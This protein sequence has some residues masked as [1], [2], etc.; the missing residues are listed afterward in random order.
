MGFLDGWRARR[1]ER[2]KSMAAEARG[3]MDSVESPYA[4]ARTSLSEYEKAL[5]FSPG[6]A[7]RHAKKAYRAAVSESEAARDHTRAVEV[8]EA[9]K[10]MDERKVSSMDSDYRDA[11]AKGNTRRATKVARRMYAEASRN[12]DP[13]PVSVTLDQSGAS[14]GEVDVVVTNRGDRPVVVQSIACSCGTTEIM[15]QRGMAEACQ[16]GQQTRHHVS[17][18]G[19]LSLGITVTVEYECGFETA[20]IRRQFSLLKQV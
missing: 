10:R 9:Q 20:R 19:D 17:F 14:E 15:S 5:R 11:L 18:D 4:A 2:A 1:Q 8:L 16:P 3:I 7:Y 6:S 13:S 12:P